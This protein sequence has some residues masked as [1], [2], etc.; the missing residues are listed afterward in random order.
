MTENEDEWQRGEQIGQNFQEENSSGV[1][2]I[3]YSQ[4]N[5]MNSVMKARRALGSHVQV[6]IFRN[7]SKDMK[8][9]KC[10]LLLVLK[11]EA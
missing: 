7:L 6:I 3:Q 1:L 5:G 8:N 2:P 10:I 11:G 9:S 4:F